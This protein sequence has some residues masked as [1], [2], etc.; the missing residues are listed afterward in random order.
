MQMI[1]M[2]MSHPQYD[3]EPEGFVPPYES[4]HH[5]DTPATIMPGE[6]LPSEVRIDRGID[7]LNRFILSAGLQGWNFINCYEAKGVI[8]NLR[9]ERQ[10]LEFYHRIRTIPN[11]C[12]FIVVDIKEE[13]EVKKILRTGRSY[14]SLVRRADGI[15]AALNTVH[16][17]SGISFWHAERSSEPRVR[18]SWDLQR[19]E[20]IFTDGSKAL[21]LA[22]LSKPV[23]YVGSR[24]EALGEVLY[25]CH[26]SR[27][28]FV[29]GPFE[30]K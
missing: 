19:S 17:D 15:I 6:L 1:G 25:H 24:L 8:R 26:V 7:C 2:I 10:A 29:P 13:E 23:F 20:V 21:A 28:I 18:N 14:S 16:P 27:V 22:A 9:S 30:H 11:G 5:N 3:Q 4:L 12:F